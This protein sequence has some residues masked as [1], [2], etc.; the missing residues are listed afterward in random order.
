VKFTQGGPAKYANRAHIAWDRSLYQGIPHGHIHGGVVNADDFRAAVR[1]IKATKGWTWR[2][3]GARGGWGVGRLN[4][5][6]YGDRKWVLEETARVFLRKVAGMPEPLTAWER[7]Q[8]EQEIKSGRRAGAEIR[9]RY[10][11]VG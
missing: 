11:E 10:M 3:M 7:R 4:G 9:R 5:V 6:M 2:E 1:R 8:H